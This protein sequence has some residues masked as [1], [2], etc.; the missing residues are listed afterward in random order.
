MPIGHLALVCGSLGEAPLD[1]IQYFPQAIC[2]VDGSIPNLDGTVD[3]ASKRQR[4]DLCPWTQVV[5]VTMLVLAG[6]ITERV[7]RRIG[8]HAFVA[9]LGR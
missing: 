8:Q 6:T 2:V 3:Y 9:C 4:F 7:E 1:E 5:D